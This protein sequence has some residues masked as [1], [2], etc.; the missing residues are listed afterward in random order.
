MGAA[1]AGAASVLCGFLQAR[2]WIQIAP[3]LL[4]EKAIKS[5]GCKT[6]SSMIIGG[7]GGLLFGVVVAGI[8]IYFMKPVPATASNKRVLRPKQVV[9]NMNAVTACGLDFQLEFSRLSGKEQAACISRQESNLTF[10]KQMCGRG[11][12]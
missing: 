12:I 2:G 4:S 5:L 11:G 7:V 8:M 1:S 10:M 9:G 6:F 3:R